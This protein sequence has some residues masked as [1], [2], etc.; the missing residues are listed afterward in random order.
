MIGSVLHQEGA[1][2]ECFGP[3]ELRATL[4]SGALP[5]RSASLEQ[6]C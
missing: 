4:E 5:S 3:V 6:G 2:G 1:G